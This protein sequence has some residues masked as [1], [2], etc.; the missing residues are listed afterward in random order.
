[1]PH[2]DRLGVGVV[3][4]HFLGLLQKGLVPH[5]RGDVLAE[6]QLDEFLLFSL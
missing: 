5:E 6:L 4:E 2:L 3:T 1:M